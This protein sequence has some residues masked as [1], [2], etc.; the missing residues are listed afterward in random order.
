MDNKF[1][2][3]DFL[4]ALLLRFHITLKD[5]ADCGSVYHRE[6]EDMERIFDL[7]NVEDARRLFAVPRLLD[8]P[9]ADT[10]IAYLRDEEIKNPVMETAEGN[11]EEYKTLLAAAFVFNSAFFAAAWNCCATVKHELQKQE[12]KPFEILVFGQPR[13]SSNKNPVI[14][15]RAA[16]VAEPIWREFGKY[17]APHLGLIKFRCL[18]TGSYRCFMFIFSPEAPVS[19][20]LLQPYRITV[21]FATPDNAIHTL[22]AVDEWGGSGDRESVASED[23]DYTLGL[24]IKKIWVGPPGYPA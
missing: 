24:A 8:P 20:E 5:I 16:S 10:I 23:I 7:E 9:A 17:K 14:E 3:A 15:Y 22:S 19:Q 11:F 6:I 2:G 13:F 18:D 1:E 12:R 4:D 21:E